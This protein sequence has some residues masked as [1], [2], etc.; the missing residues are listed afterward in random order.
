MLIKLAGWLADSMGRESE[1]NWWN[2]WCC[3]SLTQKALSLTV[4][5]KLPRAIQRK[6]AARALL[7]SIYGNNWKFI[8]KPRPI[9]T[10]NGSAGHRNAQRAKTR[11]INTNKFHA[12]FHAS[13]PAP[14]RI[15]FF[16]CI[17]NIYFS[18]AFAPTYHRQPL[19]LVECVQCVWAGVEVSFQIVPRSVFA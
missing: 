5:P 14:Y 19:P 15:R 2:C 9:Y 3:T 12:I 4:S 1:C 6:C 17:L 10:H 18:N 11:Q 7:L 16:F 13:F 8:E